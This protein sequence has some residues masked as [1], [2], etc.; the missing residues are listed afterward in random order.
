MEVC[1]LH[2]QDQAPDFAACNLHTM[3]QHRP[4]LDREG[5]NELVLLR[6]KK[7]KLVYD[8][9]L[10]L[11]FLVYGLY[12]ICILHHNLTFYPTANLLRVRLIS[13]P[14]NTHTPQSLYFLHLIILAFLPLV[15]YFSYKFAFVH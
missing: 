13:R 12:C 9:L 4:L 5:Y 11:V 2:Q 14:E 10:D 6:K 3:V 15:D 8:N 1:L 7:H